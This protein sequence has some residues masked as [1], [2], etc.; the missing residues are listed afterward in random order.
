MDNF[1]C[2]NRL[3]K[4]FPLDRENLNRPIFMEE[5]EKAVKELYHKATGSAYFLRE[6][7]QTFKV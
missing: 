1:L 6:F 2:K 3:P 7:F 5:L 4:F